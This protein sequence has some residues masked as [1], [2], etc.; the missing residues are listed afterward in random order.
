[1]IEGMA[2]NFYAA[3]YKAAIAPYLTRPQKESVAKRI[4][5]L[6]LQSPIWKDRRTNYAAEFIELK[7]YVNVPLTGAYL[8][9]ILQEIVSELAGNL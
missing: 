7:P 6:T 3:H 5:E 1:M 4:S 2:Q 9:A 8:C